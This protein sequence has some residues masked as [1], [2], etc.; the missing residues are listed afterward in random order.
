M[1]H[2][3]TGDG[4][5]CRALEARSRILQSIRSFFAAR[6]FVEVETATRLAEPA[7]ELHIDAIAAEDQFLRTSPEL[8]MKRLLAAGLERIYQV[9]PCF[10]SCEYGHLHRPE[11][12]LLE[13]YRRD[14]DYRD[15]LDDT[16]A[17]LRHVTR[18]IHGR[19]SCDW[20]GAA[21]DIG[22]EWHILTVDEAFSRFAGWDPVT[23]YD[24]DRFDVDLVGKVEPSLPRDRPVVL[25]DYP[26]EA[27]A[28]ARCR[29]GTSPPVAERWELY[30][31]GIELANAYSELID[32]RE[33]RRR[34][35]TCRSGRESAGRRA[36]P[37]D[38]A[39]LADLGRLP[40]CGGIAL[41]VDR[42]VMVLTGLQ[43]IGRVRPMG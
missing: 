28:L 24:A 5:I 22:A 27:A 38:E 10:R 37:I 15:I 21:I 26:V 41:G 1:Q 34:F 14:S 40:P 19:L 32:P 16:R 43:D 13:W 36:Y 42:L 33:Q 39:F 7:N 29:R 23:D 8:Q 3:T 12:T 2:P 31:G 6:D 4:D 30:V 18:A 11:F 17:L 35:E 9:G 20:Q 25:I